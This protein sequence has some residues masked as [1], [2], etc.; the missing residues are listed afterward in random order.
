MNFGIHDIVGKLHG[1][2]ESSKRARLRLY[3]SKMMGHEI[4]NM[5]IVRSCVKDMNEY[6]CLI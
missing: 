4:T 1:C 6:R 3:R 2:D 5:I